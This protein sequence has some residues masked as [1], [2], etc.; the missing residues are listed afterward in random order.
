MQKRV[1]IDISMGIYIIRKHWSNLISFSKKQQ[2]KTKLSQLQVA[3]MS[4]VILMVNNEITQNVS[5]NLIYFDNLT[6]NPD[7]CWLGKWHS[8]QRTRGSRYSLTRGSENDPYQSTDVDSQRS[9]ENE[10]KCNKVRW[11]EREK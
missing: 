3:V 2:N 5:H 1:C 6:I 11:L 10:A 7:Q 4:L 9:N 8:S